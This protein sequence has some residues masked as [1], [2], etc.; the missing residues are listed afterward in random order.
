MRIPTV[1]DQTCGVYAAADSRCTFVQWHSAPSAAQET[2]PTNTQAHTH[3]HTEK[4]HRSAP[5]QLVRLAHISRTHSLSIRQFTPAQHT[6][7]N[8][9]L[10]QQQPQRI[11]FVALQRLTC[12]RYL[13]SSHQLRTETRFRQRLVWYRHAVETGL[14]EVCK[15]RENGQTDRQTHTKALCYR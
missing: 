8:T 6:S 13:A 10:L 11:L 15:G 3:E 2:T 4:T 14:C 7:H 12:L 1:G 9:Y 5:Q